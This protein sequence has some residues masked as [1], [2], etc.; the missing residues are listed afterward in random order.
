MAC[1][2]EC[3]HECQVRSS[4]SI[5]P[6]EPRRSQYPQNHGR[7]SY[8]S[9]LTMQQCEKWHP[10]LPQRS[11][12]HT[13]PVSLQELLIKCSNLNECVFSMRIVAPNFRDGKFLSFDSRRHGFRECFRPRVDSNA[14]NASHE[15]AGV[16]SRKHLT[17]HS[18]LEPRSRFPRPPL[19][20]HPTQAA[21]ESNSA[22]NT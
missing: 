14:S 21:C 18:A 13:S 7:S 12:P 6:H 19:R 1:M 15:S 10:S 9:P 4:V 17:R 11:G 22:K 3:P 2:H 5:I 20:A 8:C 16:G